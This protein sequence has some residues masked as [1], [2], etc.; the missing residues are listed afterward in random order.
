[1]ADIKLSQ[2]S[3]KADKDL[4]KKQTKEKTQKILDELDELQNL[5]YAEG[6]HSLLIAKNSLQTPK[7]SLFR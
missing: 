7:N 5:L 4:D 2:I 3:T 1:M 6:K